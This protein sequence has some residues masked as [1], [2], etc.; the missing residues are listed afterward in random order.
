MAKI[1]WE[2]DR[3]KRLAYNSYDDIET[4]GVKKKSEYEGRMRFGRYKGKPFRDVPN[5]Y[6]RWCIENTEF[7]RLE[8]S[9]YMIENGISF[10]SNVRY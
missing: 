6:L 2:K 7:Q 5:D 9:N 10:D 8:I 1:N 4:K 3:R